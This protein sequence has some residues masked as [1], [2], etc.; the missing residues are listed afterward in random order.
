LIA[1]WSESPSLSS[2]IVFCYKL[3]NMMPVKPSMVILYEN[4]RGMGRPN[5][6]HVISAV[7]LLRIG[8]W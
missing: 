8:M 1:L 3:P 5:T 7:W 4:T 6:S 2:T